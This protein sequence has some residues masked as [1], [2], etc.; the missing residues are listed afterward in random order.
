MREVSFAFMIECIFNELSQP[1]ETVDSS[2][3]SHDV[4]LESVQHYHDRT[5]S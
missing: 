1:R 4:R 2:A 3:V 5:V